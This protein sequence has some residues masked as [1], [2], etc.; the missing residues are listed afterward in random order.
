M[1]QQRK[2][3][4]P[5]DI[6]FLTDP[7]NLIKIGSAWDAQERQRQHRTSN[8]ALTEVLKM[9]GTYRLEDDIHQLFD[10]HKYPGRG[11]DW[12]YYVPEIQEYVADGQLLHGYS[13]PP[14]KQETALE[15]LDRVRLKSPSMIARKCAAKDI[16]TWGKLIGS[17]P[18]S[19]GGGWSLTELISGTKG[20]VESGPLLLP[21][22]KYPAMAVTRYQGNAFSFHV[23]HECAKR[24]AAKGHKIPYGS[25]V[26]SLEWKNHFQ[27]QKKNRDRFSRSR[28]GVGA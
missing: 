2:K 24:Y 23:Y 5:C 19:A 14:D 11:K 15:Y 17:V 22:T 16:E 4:D 27:P 7:C 10:R 3:D 18:R 20:L 25:I 1:R 26:T 9:P 6:Y 21:V 12:F 28:L 8:V 13:F